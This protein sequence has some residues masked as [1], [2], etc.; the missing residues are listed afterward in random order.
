MED[1]VSADAAASAEPVSDAEDTSAWL[2]PPRYRL[3]PA[4]RLSN[5]GGDKATQ[6]RIMQLAPRSYDKWTNEEKVSC[7]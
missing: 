2:P 3:Q 4:F 5:G 1:A 7:Q 6:D